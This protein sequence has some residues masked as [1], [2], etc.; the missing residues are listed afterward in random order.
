MLFGVQFGVAVA[1]EQGEVVE[2]GF[3]FGGCF[4]RESMVHV[5]LGEGG[6]AEDAASVS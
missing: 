6:A 2:V 1:A 5:A 3:A 4:P